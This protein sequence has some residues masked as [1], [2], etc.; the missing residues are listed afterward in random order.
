[1]EID[2]VNNNS[3]IATDMPK[4]NAKMIVIAK[5]IITVNIETAVALSHPVS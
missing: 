3:S 1:M 2:V 4:S 5:K